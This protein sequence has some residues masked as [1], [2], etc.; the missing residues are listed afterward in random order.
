MC[1]LK[2]SHLFMALGNGASQI[3]LNLCQGFSSWSGSWCFIIFWALS[4]HF[5]ASSN[6]FLTINVVAILKKTSILW[7]CPFLKSQHSK[8]PPQLFVFSFLFWQHHAQIALLFHLKCEELPLPK[9][10]CLQTILNMSY[11][12]FIALMV[13]V[14]EPIII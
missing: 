1:N 10:S 6:C 4:R 13:D 11:L 3:I 12:Y 2:P 5:S 8:L 7:L 9:W 14:V